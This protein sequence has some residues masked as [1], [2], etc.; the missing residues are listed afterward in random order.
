[1]IIFH[2]G[3]TNVG[4]DEVPEQLDARASVLLTMFYH[5]KKPD[6]TW[7]IEWMINKRRTG[8]WKGQLFLDSGAFSQMVAA[9]KIAAAGGSRWSYFNTD[10]FWDYL[11][12]YAEFVKRYEHVVDYYANLDVIQNPELTYRNQ[13]VLENEYGLKPMPVV[14]YPAPIEWIERY[15]N[16]G[17]NLIG[18]GMGGMERNISR[19]QWIQ[20]CFDCVSNSSGVPTVKF[21]GFGIGGHRFMFS[22]PWWSI[23]S[24]SWLMAG[25]NGSIL[26]PRK[27][28]GT[29]DFC[30]PP[31]RIATSVSSSTKS[32]RNRHYFNL[33]E[34]SKR[35]V[36]EWLDYI[37][38]PLGEVEDGKVVKEGVVGH[39][40]YRL[41][42]NLRYSLLVERSLPEWPNT[43]ASRKRVP[44]FSLLEK[45]GA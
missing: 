21:H 19:E 30:K 35:K 5:Q 27:V 11:R 6:K 22:F 3:F 40:L 26:M 12:R 7:R 39:F 1:V 41:K 4:R 28:G 20:R 34:P 23:D 25:M 36:R 31:C 10:E 42:A 14:H 2:S 16:E 29:Y 8:E 43:C 33:S 24:T 13:K 18:L 9:K 37:G 38:V 32:E 45:G 15:V 17:Y 44:E